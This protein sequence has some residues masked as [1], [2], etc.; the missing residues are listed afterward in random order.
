MVNTRSIW[1][2]KE[3]QNGTSKT[4]IRRDKDKESR[5]NP[6]T[7]RGR[8]SKKVNE[9]NELNVDGNS[10]SKKLAESKSYSGRRT[11]QNQS[12]TDAASSTT[13]KKTRKSKKGLAACDSEV[14]DD[15]PK[16]KKRVI[17]LDPYDV[18]NKRLDDQIASNGKNFVNS[19]SV[20]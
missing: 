4:K 17:R 10:L 18:S 12:K 16:K 5:E 2:S 8:R 19:L 1:V 20:L 6:A 14:V 13:G 7:L 11:V 15:K 9:A 3:V